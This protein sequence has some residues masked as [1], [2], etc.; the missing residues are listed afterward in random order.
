[1]HV[2][3]WQAVSTH[4]AVGEHARSH[5]PASHEVTPSHAVEPVQ[6]ILLV[7]ALAVTSPGHVSPPLQSMLHEL[8]A[9]QVFGL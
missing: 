5:A 1:V 7:G 2:C 6:Q 8:V 3:A 9:L 4:E